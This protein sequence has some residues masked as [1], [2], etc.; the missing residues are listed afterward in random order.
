MTRCKCRKK[1]QGQSYTSPNIAIPIQQTV[2]LIPD[3]SVGGLMRRMVC[4]RRMKPQEI[5]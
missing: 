1:F 3:R 4:F 2:S 5:G